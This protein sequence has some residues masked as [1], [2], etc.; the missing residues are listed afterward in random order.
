[1]SRAK[2]KGS[3]YQVQVLDRAVTIL[4]AL[5]ARDGD[6]SLYELAANLDLHKSTIHRLL[7]VLERH[8]LVERGTESGKYG[9]GLKLFELGN[10]A[11]ARLGLAERARPHLERLV[12]EAGETA[13]LCIL[14]DGEVLYLE[15]V[16]PSRT[17]RVPSNVGQRNPA[18]CTAVGKALLAHL[19]DAELD[20]VI[21]SR[22]LKAYTRNTITNPALLKRELRAIRQRGYAVDDEEIDEGLRCIGA[23]VRDFSGKVVASMSIAGPAFRIGKARIPALANLVASTT[24]RFSRE[25]GYRPPS[26]ASKA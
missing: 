15:K 3:P 2:S 9:L 23:P 18:H 20:S 7:M 8:R 26:L 16:E 10:K 21:R 5:A 12:A 22:G 24:D 4:E 6:L 19:A 25:L 14:D 11:I 17:V 13:H 1:M